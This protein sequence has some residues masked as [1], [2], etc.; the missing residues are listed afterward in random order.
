M[1]WKARVL[2]YASQS[3]HLSRFF[4]SSLNLT[5]TDLKTFVQRCILHKKKTRNPINFAAELPF[6]W[7]ADTARSWGNQIN[8]NISYFHFYQA[9]H[10][11]N[12]FHK[13]DDKNFFSRLLFLCQVQTIQDVNKGGLLMNF[14]FSENLMYLIIWVKRFCRAYWD[15]DP[16]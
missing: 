4:F 6:L 12:M 7:E 10:A 11:Q 2:S 1:P 3:Q 14:F 15:F 8:L 13:K 9:I 16:S 5:S